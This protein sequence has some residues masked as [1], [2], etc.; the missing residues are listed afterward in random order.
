MSGKVS[1]FSYSSNEGGGSCP[2]WRK[3]GHLGGTGGGGVCAGGGGGVC[4]GGG[5]TS[6]LHLHVHVHVDCSVSTI[7]ISFSTVASSAS[8]LLP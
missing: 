4:V 3:I 5:S 8:I 2:M 6:D 1:V 7:L